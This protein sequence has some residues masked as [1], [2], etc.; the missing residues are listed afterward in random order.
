LALSVCEPKNAEI[1]TIEDKTNNDLFPASRPGSFITGE[2]KL[3]NQKN[4]KLSYSCV[5]ESRGHGALFLPVVLPHRI[6]ITSSPRFS[7]GDPMASRRGLGAFNR[8]FSGL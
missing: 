7:G 1:Q 2:R 4:A 6:W 5:N 3:N 8:G